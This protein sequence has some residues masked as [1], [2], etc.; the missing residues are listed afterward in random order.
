MVVDDAKLRH[1]LD[2]PFGFRVKPRLAPAGIR[3][4]D[5]LLA[6]PDQSADIKLVVEDPRAASP[7]AVNRGRS[8]GLTGWT[9]DSLLV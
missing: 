3:I 1:P 8:P 6:V 2:N 4:F 5:K 7:I 9:G